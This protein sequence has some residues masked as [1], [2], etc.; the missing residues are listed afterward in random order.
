MTRILKSKTAI[1]LILL[2]LT[3]FVLNACTSAPI[4]K[5]GETGHFDGSVFVNRIKSDKTP[6]DIVRLFSTFEFYKQSWPDWIENDASV[7][8]EVV[9]RSNDLRVTFIN[10]STFLIQVDG[11]NILTDPVYSDRVSPFGWI[12]PK[13]VRDPGVALTDLP[14]IDVVL[15]SHNHY[16]HLDIDSL[17]ALYQQQQGSEPLILAGLGNSDF[18]SE[19]GLSL[20]KDLDWLQTTEHKNMKFTF[21]ETRHRSGRGISDQ[22]KTLWGG[23]VIETSKGPIYFAGDTGYGPHFS[24]ARERFGDMYLALLPIGAYEPRWFMRAVHLDPEEAVKAHQDL[25]SKNS[26]SMH[27]GTFQLT[28]EGV[29]QPELDL[30]QALDKHKVDDARFQVLAFGQTSVFL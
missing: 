7:V 19:E 9:E 23:F 12:G 14:P 21:V 26:I 13:R 8:S 6:W 16:D 28:L 25:G 15:V 2:G 20:S 11:L 1:V 22:M 27:F 10:H 18:F 4:Y 29:S 17:K 24:E 5:G 30:A 3:V